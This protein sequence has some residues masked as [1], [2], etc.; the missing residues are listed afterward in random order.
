[1]P[2]EFTVSSYAEQKGI[3]SYEARSMIGR[4]FRAGKLKRREVWVDGNKR[5]AYSLA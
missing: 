2:G 3:S 4:A 1:M 5:L